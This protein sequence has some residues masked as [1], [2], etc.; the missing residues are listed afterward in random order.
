MPSL[1]E[2]RLKAKLTQ[3][4]LA[5]L[6]DVSERTVIHWEMGDVLPSF[7]GLHRL[8]EILGPE[9]LNAFQTRDIQKKRGR[10]PS[11][12]NRKQEQDK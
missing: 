6:I 10:K 5:E 4:G 1:K 8:S 9:V 2:L 12:E 11:Q 7:E 3:K